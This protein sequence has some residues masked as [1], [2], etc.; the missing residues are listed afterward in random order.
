MLNSFQ[1]EIE[2]RLHTAFTPIFLVV[3]NESEKHKG[4]MGILNQ[5]EN[6][7]TH[8]S[9]KMIS[10]KFK[11]IT[12]LQ[13]H[14]LVLDV[15]GDLMPFPVHALRLELKSPDQETFTMNQ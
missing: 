9:I 10:E 8:F 13:R 12:R 15:L 3:V 14:R 4:H 11:G 6:P 2:Q 7:E 5:T 1:F